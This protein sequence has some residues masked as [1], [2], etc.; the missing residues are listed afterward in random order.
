MALDKDRLGV[1]L[2]ERV[3]LI[4]GA[5][6]PAMT[7]SQETAGLTMWKGIA[8]ELIKEF[9]TNA[10]IPVLPGTFKDGAALPITGAGVGSVT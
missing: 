5:H 7:A 8:D 3:K 6:S 10:V 2:W 4:N 9:K 1:A